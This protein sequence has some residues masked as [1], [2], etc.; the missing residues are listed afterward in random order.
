M[1]DSPTL[2]RKSLQHNNANRNGFDVFET[3]TAWSS[4]A[5]PEMVLVQKAVK[6]WLV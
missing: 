5:A 4:L 1:H 6:H 3:A 2:W